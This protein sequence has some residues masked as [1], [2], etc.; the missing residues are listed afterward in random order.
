MNTWLLDLDEEQRVAATCR[1]DLLAIIAGAGC[2]K[3]R[4]LIARVCE[5]I[6]EWRTPPDEILVVCFTRAATRE[7]RD[8]LRATIGPLA[9]LV[10]IDTFHGLA[11]DIL[12]EAGVLPKT[13][14]PAT[15]VEEDALMR[16]LFS[17]PYARPEARR[18]CKRD[19][20]R[21]ATTI[22]RTADT[23]GTRERLAKDDPYA[24]ET[25]D[26]WV[27]L[28]AEQRRVPFCELLPR[29]NHY[30]LTGE[31]Q[32][33]WEH[34][35]VDE[36]HDCTPREWALAIFLNRK[37]LTLVLDPRQSIFAW[38]GGVTPEMIDAMTGPPA[39]R[40]QL[41]TSYRFGVEISEYANAIAKK[42]CDVELPDIRTHETYDTIDSFE[43]QRGGEDLP[44]LVRTLMKEVDSHDEIAILARTHE[45]CRQ[46]QSRLYDAGIETAYSAGSMDDNVRA[47]I[48]AVRLAIDPRD[49]ASYHFL[50]SIGSIFYQ[51]KSQQFAAHAGVRRGLMEEFRTW[52]EE[53]PLAHD[54]V[55]SIFDAIPTPDVARTMKLDT[56]LRRIRGVTTGNA[57]G[58]QWEHCEASP[59][60]QSTVPAPI[61]GLS[62]AD[63]LPALLDA[64]RE[65]NTVLYASRRMHL[66]MLSTVHSVKGLEWPCVV[67]LEDSRWPAY[68]VGE[69]MRVYYVAVT[70]ARRTL[71]RYIR[72][73][74]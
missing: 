16:P 58:Q 66:P 9:D 70:R 32:P 1:D 30:Y 41:S 12:H 74:I 63:A 50:S 51:I 20:Y 19:V 21:V 18:T 65:L 43:D 72:K 35:L 49:N 23:G 39:R 22:D 71:V 25:Y 7:V 53:S 5:M 3:T 11:L 42:Y 37:T 55:P 14:F 33:R 27:R 17:G 44:G 6:G 68:R 29:L 4:V 46:A 48:A 24:L 2:G 57:R 73:D 36:A 10:R 47:A 62:V 56:L 60:Y 31:D 64:E 34:V 26:T 8:R 38:R 59:D 45:A 15:E 52:R 40:C 67:I 61:L 13:T 54:V 69:D 28:L